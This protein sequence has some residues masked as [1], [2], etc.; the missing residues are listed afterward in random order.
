MPEVWKNSTGYRTRVRKAKM[1][2]A[3]NEELIQEEFHKR[4]TIAEDFN[5]WLHKE[6]DKVGLDSDTVQETVKDLLR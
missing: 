2:D 1:L 4:L 3:Y 5:A 6:G